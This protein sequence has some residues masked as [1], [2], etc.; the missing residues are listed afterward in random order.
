MFLKRQAGFVVRM[1][2]LLDMF[3]EGHQALWESFGSGAPGIWRS[4]AIEKK[5]RR[6]RSVGGRIRTFWRHLKEAAR[7]ENEVV[8]SDG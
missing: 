4:G 2:R 3:S 1:A 8:G 7:R 6:A 5:G